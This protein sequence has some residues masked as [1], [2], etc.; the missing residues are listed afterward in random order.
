MEFYVRKGIF[1]T[2]GGVVLVKISEFLVHLGENFGILRNCF[3]FYEILRA[4]F[5]FFVHFG[6]FLK[7]FFKLGIF[8]KSTEFS[9]NFAG[10]TRNFLVANDFIIIS[11]VPGIAELV[12]IFVYQIE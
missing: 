12:V 1:R 3:N 4:I 10:C 7:I 5:A 9:V 11:V 2:F 6:N 8:L